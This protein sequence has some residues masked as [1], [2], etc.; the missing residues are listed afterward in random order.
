MPVSTDVRAV[1][2][3]VVEVATPLAKANNNALNAIL[4]PD[5]DIEMVDERRLR[6]C[7]SAL[8][9]NACRFTRD[10][11]VVI[12]AGRLQ[13][14]SGRWL[15]FVVDDCGCGISVEQ[16]QNLFEPFSQADGA[17]TRKH[18]G[19]GLGLAVTQRLA[20]LMGGDLKLQSK[21]EPGARFVLTIA[22]G[23]PDDQEAAAR[24][25]AR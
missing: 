8:L 22:C 19:F 3:S 18:D 20:R 24:S 13:T 15:E 17:L 14:P 5:I 7:L 2:A 11:S 23:V 21:A 10:A 9:N 4:S 25:I 12:S 16:Q 6:E 1:F